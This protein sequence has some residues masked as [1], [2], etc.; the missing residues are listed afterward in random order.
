LG[1]GEIQYRRV[2]L[3]LIRGLTW[4]GHYFLDAGALRHYAVWKK[5][6]RPAKAGLDLSIELATNLAR[7]CARGLLGL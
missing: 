2:P 1:D 5:M 3:L 6:D 7:K 4:K